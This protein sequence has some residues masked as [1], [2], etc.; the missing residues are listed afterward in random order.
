MCSFTWET[1]SPNRFW[2]VW[3]DGLSPEERVQGKVRFSVDEV[4]SRLAYDAVRKERRHFHRQWRPD[5]TI[6]DCG[7][8]LICKYKIWVLSLV[9]TAP[10]YVV[11]LFR[12]SWSKHILDKMNRASVL[13]KTHKCERY[14]K[15]ALSRISSRHLEM[16]KSL[17]TPSKHKI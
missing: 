5:A 15:P 12:F 6:K 1:N 10:F 16:M 4:R 2:S 8:S 13:S 3:E 11:N 14:L 9:N 7:C 17:Q